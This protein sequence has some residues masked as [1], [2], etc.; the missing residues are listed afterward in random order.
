MPGAP[1]RG[2]G[3]GLAIMPAMT[4]A[5]SVLSKDQVNDA[6]PQ[7]TVLQRVGGS[8]GTA[9]IA[10]VLQGQTDHARTAAA[11]AAG[12]AHTYWWVMGVTLI[13]LVP[14]VLLARIERRAKADHPAAVIAPA[15]EPLL[16]VA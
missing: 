9:I 11:A 16:E 6:S 8:L 3:V 15:D 2:I 13:A 14:T 10:V 12:F 5:F 7:L 4:A 1:I